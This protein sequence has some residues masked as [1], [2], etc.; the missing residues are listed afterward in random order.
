MDCLRRLKISMEGFSEA[1]FDLRDVIMSWTGVRCRTDGSG[2]VCCCNWT[3]VVVRSRGRGIIGSSLGIVT[4]TGC[5][6]GT[7]AGRGS[8][9]CLVFK[10]LS[11]LLSR[12]ISS[13]A[14]FSAW[15]RLFISFEKGIYYFNFITKSLLR[16]WFNTSW[17]RASVLSGLK[18]QEK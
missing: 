16:K 15:T 12:S 9:G 18:N 7:C 1:G 13:L 11:S 6:C 4:S 14:A 3:G 17:I 5:G 10:L 8:D 2:G